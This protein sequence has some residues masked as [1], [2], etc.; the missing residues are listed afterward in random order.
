MNYRH[1]YHA[2][3]FADVFK[4]AILALLVEHLKAKPAPFHVLDTHAGI[5]RYDLAGVEAGKTGEWRQ[6]IARVLEAADRLPA[7]LGP[8]FDSVRALDSGAAGTPRWY[9]GSPRVVRHLM[10]PDDRLTLVELHPEDVRTLKAEF[11]RDRQV[12]VHHMDAYQSLKAHLPP[13]EK[14]GLVLVDPPFEATDEFARL[15]EGLTLAHRRWAGGIKALWYPVKERPAVWRFQEAVAAAGIP[16]ILRAEITIHP[17]DTHTRLNGCGMLIVN[18]PWRLDDLL[19][20]ILPPL[21]EALGA[22]AGGVLVDW[23]VPEEAA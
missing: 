3:N 13:R 1:A 19:G 2:G 5:G 23:L 16:K 12:A 21:H 22:E 17:E 7:E 6:G 18:P 4:H 15:A 8:Y 20:R 9:P 11:A 14:R 10:R